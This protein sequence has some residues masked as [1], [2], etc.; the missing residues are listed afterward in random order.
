MLLSNWNI[1]HLSPSLWV[2]SG[3]KHWLSLFSFSCVTVQSVCVSA[4]WLHLSHSV[5]MFLNLSVIPFR[6]L[7]LL[8]FS[9]PLCNPLLHS[10][11]LKAEYTIWPVMLY[12]S[13]WW[14]ILFWKTDS[15]FHCMHW[16]EG[17]WN[18]LV[19]T[20]NYFFKNCRLNL[21]MNQKPVNP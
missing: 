15:I 11:I 18:I 13:L 12:Y 3:V 5:S 4:G 21:S 2:L 20:H 14:L 10:K 9:F 1:S 19:S 8:T 6:L 17:F 7:C 16:Q